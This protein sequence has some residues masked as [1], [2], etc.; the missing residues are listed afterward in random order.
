[1]RSS[2]N[3]LGFCLALAVA[4]ATGCTDEGTDDPGA[5]LTIDNDSSYTLIEIQLSPVNTTTWGADLLGADVLEPGESFIVTGIACNLYD[6]RILD[7]D[8]DECILT[9]VDLCADDSVW[10]L[11]DLDLAACQF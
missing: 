3:S 4:G 1:M 8:N 10:Q 5:S 6:I 11:D 9:D 7:E 2:L